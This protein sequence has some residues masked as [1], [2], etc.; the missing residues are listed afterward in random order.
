M[1]DDKKIL[2]LYNV[3]N[4]Y[5]HFFS[6]NTDDKIGLKPTLILNSGINI[7]CRFKLGGS[8]LSMGILLSKK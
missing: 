8:L 4:I 6:G 7:F 2:E 3:K 5:K 1:K